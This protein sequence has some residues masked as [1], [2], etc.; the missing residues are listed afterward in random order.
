[1]SNEP[2]KFTLS[3]D[4]DLHFDM[5]ADHSKLKIMPN[6]VDGNSNI[7]SFEDDKNR[8]DSDSDIVDID[9]CC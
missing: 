3:T 6:L 7:P 1:M 9:L 4:T 5:L 2:K 8:S